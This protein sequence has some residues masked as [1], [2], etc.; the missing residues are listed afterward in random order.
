LRNDKLA[1]S[2]AT[3]W[4]AWLAVLGTKDTGNYRLKLTFNCPHAAYYI[5]RKLVLAY[6]HPQAQ[7][8]S[9]LLETLMAT[10]LETLRTNDE[11]SFFLGSFCSEEE[12]TLHG[13]V[14][15]GEVDQ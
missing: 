9:L 15:V 3:A 6:H 4:A 11:L 13:N 2:A 14:I 8:Q 10:S 1:K 7:L 5:L 12:R